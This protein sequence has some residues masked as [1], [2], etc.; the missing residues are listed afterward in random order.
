MGV[1]QGWEAYERA[2]KE[3]E[4]PDVTGANT[5]TEKDGSTRSSILAKSQI[6]RIKAEGGPFDGEE[7]S[8]PPG[9]VEVVLPA[10]FGKT[11]DMRGKVIYQRQGDVM[12][13]VGQPDQTDEEHTDE[14]EEDERPHLI[15]P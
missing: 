7:L 6:N 5:I 10:A 3:W 12:V 2:S 11:G 14:E 9:G 8:V 1:L 4:D 13:Y 15:R